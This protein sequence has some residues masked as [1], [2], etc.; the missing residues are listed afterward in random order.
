MSEEKKEQKIDLSELLCDPNARTIRLPRLKVIP[1]SQIP[2]ECYLV[3]IG[4]F[5]RLVC[6]GVG[7]GEDPLDD[8]VI[9]CTENGCYMACPYFPEE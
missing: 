7:E 3:S 2:D 4:P 1:V 9:S 8:C 5:C 6:P